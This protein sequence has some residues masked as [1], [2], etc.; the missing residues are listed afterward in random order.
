MVVQ[1]VIHHKVDGSA[2]ASPAGSPFISAAHGE[3]CNVKNGMLK[4]L[5][6]FLNKGSPSTSCG[7]TFATTVDEEYT[8]IMSVEKGSIAESSGLSP[9]MRVRKIAGTPVTVARQA[10][11]LLMAATGIVHVELLVS[12]KTLYIS[13]SDRT[14]T[15]GIIIATETARE[16]SETFTQTRV[17]RLS[18]GGLAAASGLLP[19]MLL[20]RINGVDITS[21]EQATAVISEALG[22]VAVEVY[23]GDERLLRSTLPAGDV[24]AEKADADIRI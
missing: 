11:S 7:V 15:C 18:E 6:V 3:H 9:G 4:P 24:A 23:V 20:A 12:T 14:D 17:D 5:G 1:Y 21:A 2:A 19:G 22:P 16:R 13:K 10:S 8:W